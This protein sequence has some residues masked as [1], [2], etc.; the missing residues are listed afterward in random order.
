LSFRRPPFTTA[1]RELNF[2]LPSRCARSNS[3]IFVSSSLPRGAVPPP[4][5][6]LFFF[7]LSCRKRGPHDAG[8]LS[9]FLALPELVEAPS[10]L[11]LLPPRW[12]AASLYCLL[13]VGL[14]LMY[15]L[16]VRRFLLSEPPTADPHFSASPVSSPKDGRPPAPFFL[17][18][19]TN[20]LLQK[21]A[22]SFFFYT[23]S[24]SPKVAVLTSFLFSSSR[25]PALSLGGVRTLMDNHLSLLNSQP[26]HLASFFSRFFSF[27]FSRMRQR[28]PSPPRLDPFS[29]ER[30]SSSSRLFSIFPQ[31]L[32]LGSS[33]L[34]PPSSPRPDKEFF[35]IYEMPAQIR[36]PTT[37]ND[38]ELSPPFPPPVF[39]PEVEFSQISPS[40]HP[41]PTLLR[42]DRFF[43]FPPG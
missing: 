42:A 27:L 26:N 1:I 22:T 39:S 13:K 29:T 10:P 32:L 11:L 28:I 12:L 14:E 8:R 6:K 4:S 19:A 35:F 31:G 36:K 40:L 2:P 21:V 20:V 41:L 30:E 38:D 3:A 25:R 23:A 17:K 15:F 7:S 37:R 16:E 24:S 5:R 18:M 33:F 43:F 34:F 9:F